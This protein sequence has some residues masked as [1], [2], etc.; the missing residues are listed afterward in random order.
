MQTGPDAFESISV[1]QFPMEKRCLQLSIHRD[2]ARC[3][4]N[5]VLKRGAFELT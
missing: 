3:I 5:R 4:V 2:S 1:L